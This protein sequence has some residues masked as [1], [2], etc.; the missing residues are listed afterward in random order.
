MPADDSVRFLQWAAPH[1]GLRW[2]GFRRVRRQVWRRIRKRL[3]ELG[4]TDE[5]AYRGYLAAHP[6]EW[7]RLD[8][9][10]R[11]TISRFFRDR[12][13][14][15]QL[16]S[17]VQSLA[18]TRP[19]SIWSAGC[20]SG[21]EPYSV[22]IALLDTGVDIEV[23][24]TDADPHMLDRARV[25]RY[26]SGTLRELTPELL[27]RAF[28][29][30]GD[31]HVLRPELRSRVVLLEQDVRAQTPPPGR[32]DVIFSRN[33]AFTYFDRPTQEQVLAR[34]AEA[35]HENG[36]LLIGAHESLPPHSAFEPA[37]AWPHA[38]QKR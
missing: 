37:P 30:D 3:A 11:V 20:A 36:L 18:R 7:P 26:A 25:G 29:R 34:F 14:F 9:M 2:E 22:V 35:L 8:V 16:P 6:E 21:E 12:R 23:V 28:Q 24:G 1:L 38:H 15:E 31:D 10:C 27:A 32:F 4:L 13:H 17:L 5:L 19:V 33:L